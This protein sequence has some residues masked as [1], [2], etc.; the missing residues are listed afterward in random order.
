[1]LFWIVAESLVLASNFSFG[2]NVLLAKKNIVQVTTC[3]RALAELCHN[4]QVT[5]FFTGSKRA[6]ER[7]AWLEGKKT[8][9]YSQLPSS[10]VSAPAKSPRK[11]RVKTEP[12]EIQVGTHRLSTNQPS[13]QPL[14][15]EQ[16]SSSHPSSQEEPTLNEPK[17]TSD[18]PTLEEQDFSFITSSID[19]EVDH[20]HDGGAVVVPDEIEQE[21]S[22]LGL[23]Q[24]SIPVTPSSVPYTP[25]LNSSSEQETSS[26]VQPISPAGEEVT[27]APTQS[28]SPANYVEEEQ[29]PIFS[30][31]YRKGDEGLQTHLLFMSVFIAIFFWAWCVMTNRL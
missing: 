2:K 9:P 3:L 7:I 17:P 1:M 20:E 31:A 10:T 6:E 5:P 29:P 18:T 24:P 12:S 27:L 8:Q 13:S 16:Q 26:F 14:S 28:L 23:S 11:K 21:E 30:V 4:K 25:K 19:L 15:Q 22:H